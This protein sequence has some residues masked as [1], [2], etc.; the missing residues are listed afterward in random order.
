MRTRKNLH[1]VRVQKNFS[2]FDS[3]FKFTIKK[4]YESTKEKEMEFRLKIFRDFEFKFDSVKCSRVSLV[5]IRVRNSD[6]KS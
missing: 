3:E 5:L 4:F 2:E 1:R 6:P